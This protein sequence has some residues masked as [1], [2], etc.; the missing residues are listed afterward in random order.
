M[1]PTE[2]TSSPFSARYSFTFSAK[3]LPSISSSA[4][5]TSSEF[6]PISLSRTHPPAALRVVE[7]PKYSLVSSKIRKSSFSSSVRTTWSYTMMDFTFKDTDA[8][9]S[10]LAASDV[11]AYRGCRTCRVLSPC[12]SCVA[13]C[14]PETLPCRLV[15]RGCDQVKLINEALHVSACCHLQYAPQS[16]CSPRESFR[17]RGREFHSVPCFKRFTGR[18]RTVSPQLNAAARAL[19]LAVRCTRCVADTKDSGLDGGGSADQ[20]VRTPPLSEQDKLVGIRL[21]S[22]LRYRAGLRQ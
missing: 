1:T 4:I 19:P 14:S 3:S 7:R 17:V 6:R 5:S 2:C 8:V 10:A 22:N 9:V 21:A 15:E 12:H 16:L 11:A 20:H 18:S 13:R